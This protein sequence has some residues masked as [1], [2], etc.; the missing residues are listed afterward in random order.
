MWSISEIYFP[1]SDKDCLFKTACR[2]VSIRNMGK[3]AFISIQ[4][5]EKRLQLYISNKNNNIDSDQI[6]KL[7]D[8]I[9]K[10]KLDI[11]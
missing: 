3:A 2:I 6:E 7:F 5:N 11:T 9:L 1:V 4:G 10:K 8:D